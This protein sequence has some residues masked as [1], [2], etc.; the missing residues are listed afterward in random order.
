MPGPREERYVITCEQT[1]WFFAMS[2]AVCVLCCIDFI[3]LDG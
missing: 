2:E 3:V 1:E